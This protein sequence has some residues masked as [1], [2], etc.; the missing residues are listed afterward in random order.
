MPE[1]LRR[2]I[3][4]ILPAFLRLAVIAVLSVAVGAW[5]GTA[6]GLWTALAAVGL[7][8]AL[9]L[10][11]L[12]TLGAWLEEPSLDTIPEARG[13]WAEVFNRLYKAR[14]ASE[15]NA[16]RLEENEARFRRTISALPEGIVLVDA[17]L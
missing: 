11:Y 3:Q 8:F 7:F 9:H 14:R 2:R 5:F 12:S 1:E 16:R 13:S 15:V 10:H 6:A 4:V 17:A